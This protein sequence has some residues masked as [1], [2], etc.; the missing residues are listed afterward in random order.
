MDMIILLKL[1]NY[2]GTELIFNKK[3]L[4]KKTINYIG[5]KNI[6]ICIFI[7]RIFT[8]I[9]FSAVLVILFMNNSVDLMICIP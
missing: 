4:A 7:C 5:R 3:C 8:S 1:M 9:F 2:Y 6:L